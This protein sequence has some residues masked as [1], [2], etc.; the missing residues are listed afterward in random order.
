[1]RERGKYSQLGL[2]GRPINFDLERVAYKEIRITGSFAQKRSAWKLALALMAKGC[3]QLEPLVSDT[4]PLRDWQQGFDK[5]NA[6][7]GLKI[8][9]TP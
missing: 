6:K 7:Q 3:V 9:L 8:L 1:M 5:L 4:F 2:F